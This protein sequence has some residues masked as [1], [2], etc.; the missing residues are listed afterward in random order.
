MN[1]PSICFYVS[2]FYLS[3]LEYIGDYSAN[4][5]FSITVILG[6]IALLNRR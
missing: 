6:L 2:V 5:Q 4:K 1:I 3:Y